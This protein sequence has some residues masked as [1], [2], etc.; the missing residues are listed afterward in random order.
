MAGR[1]PKPID[2]HMVSGNKSHLT[3]AEI[4]KRKNSEV[5]AHCTDVVAPE[6]IEEQKH[7]DRFYELAEQLK[8]INIL[9]DIDY[10]ALARYVIVEDQHRKAI[11]LLTKTI[12]TSDDYAKILKLQD[13]LFKQVRSAANDLGLTIS[14]RCKLVVPKVEEKSI[15]KFAKF[16][17]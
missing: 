17:G 14:S 15:N 3:K 13:S 8:A 2:L 6:Y 9:A 1:K 7:I 5:K 4:E 16:G 10:E 11:I 12:M